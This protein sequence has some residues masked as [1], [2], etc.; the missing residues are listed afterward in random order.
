MK[1][2]GI[3]TGIGAGWLLAATAV[4]LAAMVFATGPIGSR[5]LGQGAAVGDGLGELA[6]SGT[7]RFAPIDPE[8]LAGD[9]PREA[10]ER[11]QGSNRIT[12]PGSD[13]AQQ[14]PGRQTTPPQEGAQDTPFEQLVVTPGVF[15]SMSVDTG[16]ASRGDQLLYTIIVVN[17]GERTARR[18]SVNSHVPQ[19]TVW[20]GEET[21]DA[22]IDVAPGAGAPTVDQCLVANPRAD[23]HQYQRS[24]EIL[25][26]G[27]SV[28][29]AF[30]VAVAP[31]APPGTVIRNHAALTL[32]NHRKVP[33]VETRVTE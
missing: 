6:L 31:D 11:L 19:F 12:Q 20:V 7:E 5:A 33:E 10:I 23:E 30:R 16:E 1:R 28:R 27:G 13:E 3:A 25:P 29:F 26:P 24:I 14:L 17:R 8:I 32:N 15:V 18:V 9:L 4:T 21:C 22:P 2:F